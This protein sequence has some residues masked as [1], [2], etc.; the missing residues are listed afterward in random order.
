MDTWTDFAG[1]AGLV[2]AAVLAGWMLL[3]PG[4]TSPHRGDPRHTAPPTLARTGRHRATAPT[5]RLLPRL[6]PR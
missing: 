1:I 6:R 4:S 5:R 3:G 2:A